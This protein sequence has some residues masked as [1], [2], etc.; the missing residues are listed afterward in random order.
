MWC[1]FIVAAVI[2]R[3]INMNLSVSI[4]ERPTEECFSVNISWKQL[5]SQDAGLFLPNSI[6]NTTV[7]GNWEY[8]IHFT[9]ITPGINDSGIISVDDNDSFYTLPADSLVQG[10][11]YKLW[12]T[13]DV[14]LSNGTTLRIHSL[15]ITTLLPTC[16]V[17][18]CTYVHVD[19]F[20]VSVLNWVIIF[21]EFF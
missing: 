5:L 13:V 6:D 7:Y 17:G 2:N 3:S 14:F 10:A 21:S 19:N 8:L 4:S 15:Q 18:P 9:S 11:R 1:D 12:L 20:C 16:S